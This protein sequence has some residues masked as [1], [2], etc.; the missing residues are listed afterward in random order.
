VVLEPAPQ[1]PQ[2]LLAPCAA[3]GALEGVPAQ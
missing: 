2:L 1:H 3:G